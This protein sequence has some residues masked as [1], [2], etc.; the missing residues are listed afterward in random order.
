MSKSVS[1]KLSFPVLC[2]WSFAGALAFIAVVLFDRSFQDLP[3][4]LSQL[5]LPAVLGGMAGT[6]FGRTNIRMRDMSRRFEESENRFREFYQRTPAMLHSIDREG[7]LLCVSQSWL[8]TLG[9]DR[10]EV[11]DKDFFT[12]IVGENIPEIKAKHLQKLKTL[13]EFRDSSYK[14]RLAN[15]SVIDVSISE[16]ALSDF[17]G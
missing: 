12:F 16:V 13:G 6:L 7:R 5:W 2:G 9:Y 1:E 11:I 4:N 17:E 15:G 8:D 3:I 10:K 14:L